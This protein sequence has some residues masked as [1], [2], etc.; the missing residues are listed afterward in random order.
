MGLSNLVLDLAQDLTMLF[1]PTQ[2]TQE[3]VLING[4]DVRSPMNGNKQCYGYVKMTFAPMEQHRQNLALW[5]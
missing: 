2:I 1:V 3:R 5:H 4:L